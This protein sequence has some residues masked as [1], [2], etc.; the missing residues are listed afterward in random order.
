MKQGDGHAWVCDGANEWW[1][2]IRAEN[3][4]ENDITFSYLQ[5]HM[6]WGWGGSYDGWFSYGNFNPTGHQ[7]SEN[8]KMIYQIKP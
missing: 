6:N 7:Y 2:C 1:T 4:Y 8:L 3:E 5:F